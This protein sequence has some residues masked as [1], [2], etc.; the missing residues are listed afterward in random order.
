MEEPTLVRVVDRVFDRLTDALPTFVSVVPSHIYTTLTMLVI[1]MI[2]L[3]LIEGS[4]NQTADNKRFL[5]ILAF[6]ACVY[7]YGFLQSKLYY[8]QML[9]LNKQHF[10]NA[11]WVAKYLH[12]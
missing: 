8:F 7:G 12:Y 5:S 11:F 3:Y 1:F 6:V 2:T 4:E 10:T 9:A